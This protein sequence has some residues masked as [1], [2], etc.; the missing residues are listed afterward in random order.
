MIFGASTAVA[1]PT[2]LE[3]KRP[4]ERALSPNDSSH[5][6]TVKSREGEM[7]TVTVAQ[8]GID[9]VVTVLGPDGKQVIEV[10][11]AVENDGT[12]GS[13]VARVPAL[14]AGD[15]RVRVTPFKRDDAKPAKYTITVTE[16]RDLTA[17]ER[18]N[19]QS[20]RE[21]TD[22]EQRWE[23]ARDA[24]DQTTLK[25][26]LREDAFGMGS[27]PGT[28]RIREQIVAAWEA[29]AQR[30]AKSGRT[31]EHTI[32]ERKVRAA[33]NV[34]VSTFRVV[35]T[36]REKGQMVSRNTGQVVHVWGK[37]ASGWKLV[38][39]YAFPYGRVPTPP[40]D[41]VKVDLKVLSAYVGTYRTENTRITASVENGVLQA[42][43]S[44]STVEGGKQPLKPLTETTF[45]L[46]T[47]EITFVRS[48]NRRRGRRFGVS[49]IG[50]DI[51]SAFR[52]MSTKPDQAHAPPEGARVSPMCPEYRVTYV[53]GR[54]HC[55][56]DSVIDN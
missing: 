24:L 23:Q 30:Q 49:A 42:Q 18:M 55:R 20:E 54:T 1:Q 32:S 9:V 25:G 46:G 16:V 13:E 43:L 14:S 15:Y 45:A 22:I 2:S 27:G 28:P 51:V 26:I 29:E 19:L 12:G 50:L 41:G 37:D 36:N 7:F 8:Q 6:Y 5:E 3:T 40:S 34:G 47:D 17:N 52:K 10:D 38:G 33:G 53:S 21:I 48:S 39:D 4:V 11:D 56:P 31:R 35:I 44:S